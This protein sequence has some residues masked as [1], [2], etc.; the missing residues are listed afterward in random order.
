MHTWFQSKQNVQLP[1]GDI[2]YLPINSLISLLK[3]LNFDRWG[4]KSIVLLNG[5]LCLRTL[6]VHTFEAVEASIVNQ[7]IYLK[8]HP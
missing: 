7:S 6:D 2:F 3:V 4:D 1:E 8:R 5:M